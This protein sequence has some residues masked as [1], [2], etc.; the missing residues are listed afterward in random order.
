MRSQ[1]IRYLPELDHVRGFAALLILF[2]HG[3]HIFS[4]QFRFD[5]PFAF[6]NWP[7]SDNP[8]MAFLFEA[9][10]SLS[11]FMTLSGFLFAFACTGRDIHYGRF[12]RNRVLRIYPLFLLFL[13]A[14]VCAFPKQFDFLSFVQTLTMTGNINGRLTAWPFTAMFWAIAVEFQFY[15]LFPALMMLV[16]R[17]GVRVLLAL[18]A[19]MWVLRYV[20]LAHGASARD[21]SYWTLLGRADQF[22][23]GMM[24][25][26]LVARDRLKLHALY[27]PASAVGLLLIATLLNRHGGWPNDASWRILLPPAEAL[28]CMLFILGYCRLGARLPES[29][30]RPLVALGVVSFSVYLWHFIV[31]ST[32]QRNHWWLTPTGN[33]YF[34]ALLT[35]ALLALPVTLLLSGLTWHNVEKPFLELRKHYID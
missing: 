7:R 28:C 6:E 15:L 22:L 25:G 31:I 29:L 13:I 32:L 18:L 9:H 20:G 19:L 2:Y 11:L 8:L 24:A 30:H 27:L 26:H 1:N 14:G 35:T 17:R 3:L 10:L 5:A 33:P 12:L 4:Y 21:M 16:N 23:V 34:D